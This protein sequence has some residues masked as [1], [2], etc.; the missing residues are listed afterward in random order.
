MIERPQKPYHNVVLPVKQLGTKFDV[1]FTDNQ[2]SPSVYVQIDD[3][4]F[5]IDLIDDK[6]VVLDEGYI[7]ESTMRV[8][9]IVKDAWAKYIAENTDALKEGWEPV[10]YNRIVAAERR[11][12]TAKDAVEAAQKQLDNAM[13]KYVAVFGNQPF[14]LEDTE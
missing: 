6:W 14:E 12:N 3:E 13:N 9:N 5:R 2:E 8:A 4:D 10:L 7:S 11:M 1:Q